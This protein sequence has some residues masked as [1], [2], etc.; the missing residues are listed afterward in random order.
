MKILCRLAS[1]RYGDV[2]CL[3][4]GKPTAEVFR[5]DAPTVGADAPAAAAVVARPVAAGDAAAAAVTTASAASRDK[6]LATADAA[7]TAADTLCAADSDPGSVA[8][9]QRDEELEALR[10]IADVLGGLV[11]SLGSRDHG[12][13][14]CGNRDADGVKEGGADAPSTCRISHQGRI[15]SGDVGQGAEAGK[16]KVFGAKDVGRAGNKE[17]VESVTGSG[18][19][20]PG[21][22]EPAAADEG[23]GH[24]NT[25]G[26]SVPSVC[27]PCCGPEAG[28]GAAR[29]KDNAAG[30][31]GCVDGGGG[32]DGGGNS[33]GGP[34]GELQNS[35]EEQAAGNTFERKRNGEAADGQAGATTT[36]TAHTPAT[37]AAIAT[38]TSSTPGLEAMAA[39]GSAAPPSPALLFPPVDPPPPG[40]LPVGVVTYNQVG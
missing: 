20:S 11:D 27:A 3:P 17:Q 34:G 31:H 21:T 26:G 38:A 1:I 36:A 35:A 29:N 28:R 19:G 23:G 18:D 25:R 24:S 8:G 7:P 39:A 16:G 13:L 40:L 30:I 32:G 5:D 37:A 22:G 12:G 15:G 33:A 6:G 9:Q 14:D 10:A 2:P 4:A